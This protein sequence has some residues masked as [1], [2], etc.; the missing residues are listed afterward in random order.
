MKLGLKILE[1][2][3]QISKEILGALLP[4]ITKYLDRAIKY[5]KQNLPDIVNNAI[6]NAPE[7]SSLISGQLRYEFGLIDPDN[8]I[9]G[10]LDIWINNIEYVYDPPKIVGSNIK[11]NFSASMIRIDFSDVLYSEYAQMQD[12]IRGYSL[13]WLEWLLL[14][15][16]KVLVP[17]HSVVI[18]PNPRSRTGN[19]VMVN[20]R[21]SWK[22]PAQFAGSSSDNWIT[23][24]LDSAESEIQALLDKAMV[25]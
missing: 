6:T 15:G 8:K 2:N 16:N 5:I 25:I 24:A 20:S 3:S 13:P 14:E 23:R 18:G 1:N 22:V 7:Y 17:N 12:T 4:D 19:A 21:S 11:S 9:N 10:L